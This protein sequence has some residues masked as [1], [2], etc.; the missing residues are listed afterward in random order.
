MSGLQRS[1]REARLTKQPSVSGAWRAA[2]RQYLQYGKEL[3]GRGRVF[4]RAANAFCHGKRGSLAPPAVLTKNVSER[5][6]R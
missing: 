5:G 1:G 6:L 2:A 3:P 4:I